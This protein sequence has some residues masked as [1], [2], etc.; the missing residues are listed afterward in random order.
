MTRTMNGTLKAGTNA[1]L[2]EEPWEYASTVL[3]EMDKMELELTLVGK[4]AY[5]AVVNATTTNGMPL[6]G[7]PQIFAVWDKILVW[8][9]PNRD[10]NVK[11]GGM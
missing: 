4:E 6:V 3:L 1:I 10:Y 8:P 5:D 2:L 7:I 9:L 11:V